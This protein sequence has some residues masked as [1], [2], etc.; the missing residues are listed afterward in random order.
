MYAGKVRTPNMV[1]WPLSC[2]HTAS[3][4]PF[5]C[6]AHPWSR[7]TKPQPG[8][9][10]AAKLRVLSAAQDF[11]ITA[12]PKGSWNVHT[13][14]QNKEAS[15]KKRIWILSVLFCVG[16]GFAASS[17]IAGG[18]TRVEDLVWANGVIWDTILTPASF[19]SP[20]LH[21]VDLL[22]TFDMSGLKGQ[23]P[24]ADSHPGDKAYNGGRWWVQVVVFT[25]EGKAAHDPDGDGA[26]NF[27]LTSLE[28]LLIHLDLGHLEI[29]ETETYFECPLLKSK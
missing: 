5:T 14:K 19:K 13:L 4:A 12:L 8:K 9:P 7:S 25:D 26:V 11:R 29:F 23:R 27:E 6:L 3:R 10:G 15:M 21:S 22:F 17:A 1:C 2:R 20:P 16:L 28:E 18:A 24:I